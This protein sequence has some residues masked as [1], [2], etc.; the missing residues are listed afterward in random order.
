MGANANV[1][2]PDEALQQKIQELGYLIPP[3][4]EGEDRE[5]VVN[6]NVPKREEEDSHVDWLEAAEHEETARF[7]ELFD[8][9]GENLPI[10]EALV[11]VKAKGGDVDLNFSNIIAL[12]GDFFTNREGSQEYYPISNAK[13]FGT[14]IHPKSSKEPLARFESAVHSLLRDTDGYLKEVRDLI[15]TE[16]HTLHAATKA[17]D[18][19][20]VA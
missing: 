13:D 2:G 19:T 9:Q 8:I 12:A 5:Y 16:H 10:D 7:V 20:A 17:G 11:T 6:S 1:E 15:T 18:N 14:L 3:D 4:I